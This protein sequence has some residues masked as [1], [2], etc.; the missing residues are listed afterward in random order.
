MLTRSLRFLRHL[1]SAAFMA[2]LL[3]CGSAVLLAQDASTGSSAVASGMLLKP[4]PS[5][6]TAKIDN[7]SRV[8]LGGAVHPLARAQNDRGVVGDG[9]ALNRIHVVLKRSEDQEAALKQLIGDMHT[10]GSASYHQWLTPDQFGKQFGPSDDDVAAI[11]NWLTSQGFTVGKLMP[12]RQTLEISGSAGQFKKAFNTEIHQYQ[13][14]GET[15][16]AN[17]SVPNI[18]SA[19]APVFGGFASLNNFRMKS[20]AKPL[21][22]AKY[23]LATKKASPTWTIGDTSGLSF[24]LSPADYAIQYDLP[25]ANATGIS[26]AGQ[27]IAVIND[28][29]VNVYL[30]NQF[31]SLFGLPVNPPQIIVDGED[32]GVDGINNVDGPNYNSVEAYLDVEWAGA[33]APNATIDL[34]IGADTELESGLSLA[35]ERAVYSNLAPI[36]SVSFGQCEKYQGSNNAF[37][38]SLWQQAAAQGI[39]VLVSS[40]DNGSAGCDDDNTQAYAVQGQAVNGLASTPYNVAVGGTDFYYSQYQDS[41]NLRTQL[42]SYWDETYQ[43]ASPAASIKGYIPEQPWNNSQYG[44]SANST[45][46]NTGTTTIAAGGGGASTCGI[47]TSTTC[48]PYPKPSWQVGTGVPADGAR[49]LPDVSL[50]ASNGQNFSV[51][52]ICATDGDCQPAPGGTVQIFGVGGTSAATPAFA[53]MMALVNQQYGRQ[54]Q[55]NYTLYKLAAQYPLAFHDVTVGSI[56]VPCNI[57]KTTQGNVPKNCIAVSN[58]ITGVADSTYGTAN[59]GQIGSGTT[60][61]YNATVGYDLASGLGTID[62]VQMLANWNKIT[63]SASTTTLTPSATNITHGTAVT[64][65]GKVTGTGTPSGTVALMTDSNQAL[66]QGQ[67]VFSLSAGSYS[68]SVS[69]LPG[70]T[71]NVYGQYGGDGSNAASTSGKTSIT[72]TPENAG[73]ALN[74]VETTI[75]P[76]TGAT[77]TAP[78]AAGGGVSYGQSGALSAL[79]APVAQLSTYAS[80]TYANTACP[81]FGVPTGSVVFSDNGTVINT[82]QVNAEG[83]AEYSYAPSVGAHSTV[84]TYSGDPSYSAATSSAFA[85]TV[86]KN[87]PDL[88]I[89][90]I[91]QN[92]SGAL[93]GGQQS[94][95]TLRV[96]NSSGINGLA[97]A[98]T[99]TVT[100]AGAPT[101]TPTTVT[102]TQSVDPYYGVPIGLAT[103]IVPS[104]VASGNYKVTLTY[105]GDGNYVSTAASATIPFT[106]G[107]GLTSTTSGTVSATS[108]TPSTPDVITVTVAGQSGG[109][110]PTGTLYAVVSDGATAPNN[111]IVLDQVTLPASATSSVTTTLAFSSQYLVQGTNVITLFYAGDTTYNSSSGVVTIQN[112]LSDFSI[113]P[114]ATNVTIPSSGTVT[115]TVNITSTAGFTGPVAL[116]CTAGGGVTCLL[117]ATSVTLTGGQSVPV[118]LTLN[119]AAVTTAGT[120]NVSITGKDATGKYVHVIGLQV[121]A[122]KSATAADFTLAAATSTL[123]VAAPNSVT[124]VITVGSVNSFSGAV[125]MTCAAP[126]GVTCTVAPTPVSPVSGG[127]TTSTLSVSGVTAGTYTVV[128]TGTSGAIVHT[129]SV[130]VTVSAAPDFAVTAAS[131]TASVVVGSTT[132]DNISVVDFGGF[133]NAVGL[134]CSAPS[135]VTCSLSL[136][137]VNPATGAGISVLTLTGVTAGSYTVT[138]TGTSGALTHSVSISVTVTAALVP[139]FTLSAT[140]RALTVVGG[141]STTNTIS[142]AAVN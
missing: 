97:L 74:L 37:F 81:V 42:M 106:S 93:V 78:L 83:E 59:E 31:R 87:T 119:N 71:Y 47:Y 91:N 35:A 6:I 84:A 1:F 128:V 26:G 52:P 40:G 32:P 105:N 107:S 61:E 142:V 10:Q 25:N 85:Y 46:T 108:S 104:G 79:I 139:S 29:N 50:F 86:T 115:D 95:I 134:A 69:S 30:V 5:R 58:P 56:S 38:N 89:S 57:N 112:P 82:T 27:T 138:V 33:V 12:G 96:E 4:V 36:M 73:V 16:F 116:S 77:S 20:Y 48:A 62:A 15:H 54:G 98:P 132:T 141:S 140:A 113:N 90:Y 18:P 49:D 94:V 123:S 23:D 121:Y 72:V 129:V 103:I 135:G 88:S 34:V 19:L 110:T 99:G 2:V 67:D 51:Y 9:V 66:Q 17:A 70:G 80:C 127:T 92:S 43:N 75:N 109:K 14:N 118:T 21:G 64:F 28:S 65:S 136:A 53:G 120:Y 39:T 114:V 3:V 124:D 63:Y 68:G 7:A 137:S 131:L 45:Y 102:L 130:A 60:A 44:L 13:V 101:G 133:T 126:S 125:A 100:V 41:S 122:P 22:A 11:E 24:V 76:K 117:S 55:A 111:V 8:T